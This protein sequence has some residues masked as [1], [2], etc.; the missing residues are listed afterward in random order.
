MDCLFRGL[1]VRVPLS[2][3]QT[4]KRRVSFAT[5]IEPDRSVR[6]L[7]PIAN[8]GSYKKIETDCLAPT[9]SAKASLAWFKFRSL[10]HHANKTAINS[11]AVTEAV[12]NHQPSKT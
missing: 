7:H 3:V 12:P 2:A 9:I 6:L 8:G 1:T 5:G 11:V 4:M 10:D